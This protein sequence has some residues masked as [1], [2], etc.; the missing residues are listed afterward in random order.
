MVYDMR[1]VRGEREY[2]ANATLA[3]LLR[4]AIQE[5]GVRLDCHKRRTCDP[6][7]HKG[8]VEGDL[9]MCFSSNDGWLVTAREAREIAENIEAALPGWVARPKRVV[10]KEVIYLPKRRNDK[11]EVTEWAAGVPVGPFDPPREAAEIGAEPK[12]VG[13]VEEFV[14]FCREASKAGGFYVY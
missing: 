8:S 9:L 7:M 5:S 3:A 1:T 12:V 2:S 6:T 4:A 11:G 10:P 14:A 13:L